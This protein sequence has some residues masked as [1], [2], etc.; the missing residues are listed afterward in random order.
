MVQ[1][2]SPITVEETPAEVGAAGL[3]LNYPV[4]GDAALIARSSKTSETIFP[5]TTLLSF[6]LN[7]IRR[8]LNTSFDFSMGGLTVN[9]PASF[10]KDIDV[11][12]KVTLRAPIVEP[13]QAASKA[14]VDSLLS[15]LGGL[16]AEIAAR[17]AGDL[18]LEVDLNSKVSK[19]GS[20]MTGLLTL[21]G[22]PTADKHAA[23]KK[24]VDDTALTVTTDYTLLHYLPL[25]GGTL[26]D[27]GT[28]V[29]E[30][31]LPIGPNVRPIAI[32]KDI[33][34]L[35]GLRAVT[36]SEFL[37]GTS[38]VLGLPGE[39]VAIELVTITDLINAERAERIAQD[40]SLQEQD[41]GL[42]SQI[43]GLLP[44]T[45]GTML[46]DL[47]LAGPPST[48]LMAATKGYVD[49]VSSA[50]SL[51]LP[52]VGGTLSGPGNLA[53]AGKLGVGTSSPLT[54][55]DVK[56]GTNQHLL[57]SSWLNVS[58]GV[59]L[60][61]V[62]DANSAW[63]PLEYLASAHVFNGGN[64]GVGTVSP[65]FLATVQDVGGS[66]F[67][68]DLVI[69]S[70]DDTN[71]WRM[72]LGLNAS[73]AAIG[74]PTN[75]GFMVWEHG[76]GYGAS[77]GLVIGTASANSGPLILVG[78][79]SVCATISTSA[80]MTM[81]GTLTLAGA[82]TVDLHAATKLYVD[83][84][85]S[86]ATTAE[87]TKEPVL[88]NPGTTGYVLAST[89]AGVRSWR[90]FTYSDVGAQVAGSYAAASHAHAAGDTTSGTFDIARIPTGTTS[91]TVSLGNHNHSGV[92]EPVLGN[93]G[94]TGYVLASTTAGVRSWRTFTYG[95]VGAAASSHTHAESDITN[96][97]TDLAAKLALAGGT[98]TGMLTLSAVPTVSLH[99]A[100]KGY[101]DAQFYYEGATDL[102]AIASPSRHTFFRS[103]TSSPSNAPVAAWVQGIQFT[104]ANNDNY[105]Q[106]LVSLAET[107]ITLLKRRVFGLDGDNC[108]T[109]EIKQVHQQR[110]FRLL[111][112]Q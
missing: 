41:A 50:L 42:Q 16:Q 49:A 53:M 80:N 74:V 52:L 57:V 24:Y 54:W 101:V 81:T 48:T 12:G 34:D 4:Q 70:G 44:Y 8:G 31:D 82:P 71:F 88:G 95:D 10:V 110:M 65:T 98:M 75:A 3:V 28:L 32:E 27:P 108:G 6:S 19:S 17:I 46:G 106:L 1:F 29:V 5:P 45:G 77:A 68:R 105:R 91:T 7:P 55:V 11:Q 94:T 104:V 26:D 9:G 39:E 15:G 78:G 25:E 59:S 18:S 89:T 37:D 38:M 47:V 102:Y 87:G 72:S 20:V 97:T 83:A 86:R 22:A 21:S 100:T 112:A 90:T 36:T 93:P 13:L 66:T 107:C 73:T 111:V 40:A 64:I 56:T 103:T 62:N 79:G 2:I 43:N 96:L 109:V 14:Y 35:D 63:V 23:T 84:E 76:G 51:Y 58:S 92:Y 33:V 60:R 30:G 61:A 99:A 69:R 67:N 85:T